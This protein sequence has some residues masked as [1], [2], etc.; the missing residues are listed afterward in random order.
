M[1][2]IATLNFNDYLRLI[3]SGFLRPVCKLV[4]LRYDDTAYDEIIRYPIIGSSSNL[5]IS[6][7]SG[8][9]RS[10]SLSFDNSDGKFIFDSNSGQMYIDTRFQFY[11]G[12][13]DENKDAFYHNMGTY[14]L[15]Q[16]QPEISSNYSER[17][18]TIKANDKFELLNTNIDG[19][20]YQIQQGESITEKIKE[21]LLIC[22]DPQTPVFD[23]DIVYVD[24]ADYTLRWDGSATYGQIIKEL[25]NMHG[26]DV[27]YDVNGQ[28]RYQK[29]L[30]ENTESSQ[31]DYNTN[32]NTLQYC[33]ASRILMNDKVYNQVYVTSSNSD[34]NTY[35]ALAQN[36]DLTSPN[37]I[38]AIP[39]HTLY[40]SDDKISSS[41]MAQTRAE[42]ELTRVK[43]LQET[44]SLKSIVLPHLTCNTAITITD[45]AFNLD[46]ARYFIKNISMPLDMK[47]TM[48][49][50]A[51]KY[52]QDKDFVDFSDIPSVG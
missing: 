39:K 2:I 50:T 52:S 27:F 44:I 48:T 13:E 10:I 28:L 43:N 15:A 41:A 8:C 14:V 25:A 5:T 7:S 40:I 36:T 30:D 20:I 19:G 18:V 29:F 26:R 37:R 24:K 11:L 3:N 33:G 21:L 16:A 23:S 38:G 32:T 34:G 12:L 4:L 42:T 51:Y 22:N 49:V 1:I 45:T 47:S 17:I 35:T 46:H 9:R 6:N 31:W